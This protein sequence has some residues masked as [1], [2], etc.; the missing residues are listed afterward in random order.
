MKDEKKNGSILKKLLLT[1]GG[2]SLILFLVFGGALLSITNRSFTSLNRDMN[3]QIAASRG[4]EIARWLEGQQNYVK[5]VADL[6]IIRTGTLEEAGNYLAGRHSS[7]SREIAMIFVSDDQGKYRSSLGAA[8]DISGRDYF[9]DIKSG[10]AEAVVSNPVI[11]KSMGIPIFVIARKVEDSNGKFKGIIA[12]TVKLETLSQIAGSVKIGRTGYGFILDGTRTVLA[13]PEQD[14]IMSTPDSELYQTSLMGIEDLVSLMGEDEKGIQGEFTDRNGNRMVS[15]LHTVKMTPGWILGIT[16]SRSEYLESITKTIRLIILMTAG[17][18]LILVVAVFQFARRF[19]NTIEAA[20]AVAVQI[21]GGD[22]TAAIDP[23]LLKKND[24]VG[25]LARALNL[26]TTELRNSF[27]EI[28]SIANQISDGSESISSTSQLLSEGATEQ[29]AT[30]QE[31]SASMDKMTDSINAN[32]DNTD[33]TESIANKVAVSA[34]DGGKAVDDTI[35]YSKNISDKI[36]IISEIARQTNM[37]ALNAA[38]EAARAG[39]A[40]SGFAVVAGEVRKLAVN[41]QNAAFEI[42]AETTESLKVASTAGQILLDHVIPEIKNT[43]E[44]V[45]EVKAATQE[46]RSE[47][48]QINTAL[49][50]LDTVIQQNAASSEELASMAEEFSSQALI[51][52]DQVAR[53]K[54]GNRAQEKPELL[55]E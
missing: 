33:M 4:D 55:E 7:F 11:S 31:V 18:I 35:T 23:A 8:G 9:K 45:S 1:F 36:Q 27:I 29:A 12:A 2:L 52:S 21:A 25:D 39:T 14:L 48:E 34:G 42:I 50:Q 16:I 44:L 26:M 37:L 28:Q 30:S 38:I 46:Q 13:H 17:A 32:S 3:L 47:A 5:G 41:S 49:R 10:A 54:T 22:L 15:F 24:E 43:A 20:S 6:N 19:S 51:L 40:G 53:F